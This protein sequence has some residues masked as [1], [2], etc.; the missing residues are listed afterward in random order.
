ML[1]EHG[2]T[3]CRCAASPPTWAYGPALSTTASPARTR[4]SRRSLAEIRQ[5]R[6]P[7]EV[8]T[9][10]AEP[11]LLCTRAARRA[12]AATATQPIIALVHRSDAGPRAPLRA[13]PGAGRGR[14]TWPAWRMIV[15]FVLAQGGR[16][17]EDY[18][19]SSPW[20]WTAPR[21]LA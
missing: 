1:D 10:D 14:R 2:P 13:A 16:P 18:H 21:R 15:R 17:A 11:H 7:A 9:W 12:E 19:L 5:R 4:C 20:C 3:R 8:V 6:R